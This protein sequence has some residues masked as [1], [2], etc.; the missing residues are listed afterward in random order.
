MSNRDEDLLRRDKVK[1]A[2]KR[3]KTWG[4]EIYK[5]IDQLPAVPPRKA[6]PDEEI[7]RAI[8]KLSKVGLESTANVLRW[9]SGKKQ[10]NIRGVIHWTDKE[11]LEEE[12]K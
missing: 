6:R 2:I 3:C 12:E 8:K 9:A 10:K 11:L 5:A 4:P 1:K 7:E